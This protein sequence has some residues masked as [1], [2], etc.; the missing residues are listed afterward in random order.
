MKIALIVEPD[1]MVLDVARM[2]FQELGYRTKTAQTESEALQQAEQGPLDVMFVECHLGRGS[3]GLDLVKK[4]RFKRPNLPVIYTTGSDL[5]AFSF[6]RDPVLLKPY[7]LE[8]LRDTIPLAAQ[9]AAA[10]SCK[11]SPAHPH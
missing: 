11:P 3:I 1:P 8:E 10:V 4:I 6:Y 7:S 9:M 5:D 2:F